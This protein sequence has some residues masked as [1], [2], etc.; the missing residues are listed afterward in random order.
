MTKILGLHGEALAPGATETKKAHETEE[1]RR[2]QTRLNGLLQQ[3]FQEYARDVRTPQ[4]EAPVLLQDRA[5]VRATYTA[6]WKEQARIMNDSGFPHTVDAEA[7]DKVIDQWEAQERAEQEQGTPLHELSADVLKRYELYKVP[8]ATP[9]DGVNLYANSAV[10]VE[11]YST[12]RVL[13][14]TRVPNDSMERWAQQVRMLAEAYS[15][16]APVVDADNYPLGLLL[17]LYQVLRV[18]SVAEIPG[19]LLEGEQEKKSY[20]LVDGEEERT[21]LAKGF[22]HRLLN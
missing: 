17:Q 21:R 22:W 12:G 16:E 6:K 9:Q 3:W 20:Q 15:G 1:M 11:V 14:W 18:A 19:H 8:V 4:G 2:E 5:A 7:L 13:V 10:A